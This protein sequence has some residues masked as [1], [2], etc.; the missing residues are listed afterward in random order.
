[1]K[2]KKYVAGL[3]LVTL[4]FIS[5]VI[6]YYFILFAL[7][8]FIAGAIIILFSRQALNQ[9]ILTIILPVILWLPSS[10]VFL[11]IYNHTSLK[12]FLIPANYEGKLRIV[13]EEDCGIE[14]KEENGEE[15]L[16]FPANG[17]II[18]KEKFDGGINNDYFLID[19]HGKRIK[20]NQVLFYN[21][22]I[23]EMP[24]VFVAGA[25]TLGGDAT[26]KG[27]TFCDYYIYNRDTTGS[28]NI[29]YSNSFDKLTDSLV[30][31][32]RQNGIYS[33]NGKISIARSLAGT[34]KGTSL[35]QDKNSSC[36]DENVVYYI[37]KDSGA[38]SYQIDGKKI[39]DGKEH[40]MGTLAFLLDPGKN[41]LFLADSINHFKWEFKI[42]GM[43]MHGTLISNGNLFRVIDL[44]KE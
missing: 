18:L 26:Q 9:K 30:N 17:L 20:I 37:S 38:N 28:E 2:D 4:S 8:F 21:E 23:K 40:D 3:M 44:K 7:P 10:F 39:I 27:I 16:E 15:V 33:R 5:C 24:A 19:G 11:K 29:S 34:W 36:H 43:E 25:G 1:M 41:I 32:C 22:K 14:P 13:Y 12:T 42:S 31:V 6:S 35:C